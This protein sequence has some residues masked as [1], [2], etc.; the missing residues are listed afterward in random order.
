MSNSNDPSF[1]SPIPFSA[2]APPATETYPVNVHSP[3]NEINQD[4]IRSLKSQG[5]T[6]GLARSLTDNN[7][8]FPLRIWVVDN[9]GSMQ[10][11]DGHRMVATSAKND[12][13][14]VNCTRWNEIRECVTYHVQMS[15][16]LEAPTSFRLLN[17]PGASVGTQQFDIA[18][19]GREAISSDV[20]RAMDIMT[21][22]RPHG[23]TP[24]TQHVQGIYEIV[25]AMTP[26]LVSEGKRVVIVLA[27]DGL[28]S[29]AHGETNQIEKNMFSNALKKLERLPVWVVIRLCTDDDDVVEYYNSLDEQLELSMDVLDDFV[30]EAKEVC[31]V[32]P[33]LN[34]ALP[35]HRM[36]EMGFHDRVFDILDERALTKAEL[37]DFCRLL[38]GSSSF[39]GVRDPEVNFSG[40]LE[41]IQNLLK[42]EDEQYNPVKG[43][44]TPWINVSTLNKMYGNG[45][46]CNI[47]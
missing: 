8:N 32:N 6:E 36:R 7:T 11:N 27:T 41:D 20:Q 30:G 14:L 22:A 17:H 45:G 19:M 5:F 21:K 16:L 4:Q 24:L 12:I 28:P 40:F 3:A 10:M 42:K 25:H 46:S 39:D 23:T 47:M 43:K 34:Y 1:I 35:L 31:D 33:W 44:V 38:F 29:N 13:K 2:S 37:R 15:A 26:S 18:Q 9:S